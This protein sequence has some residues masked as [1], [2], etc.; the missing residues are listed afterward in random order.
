MWNYELDT[1][2][3]KGK[4]KMHGNHGKIVYA[5]F[6]GVWMWI[7]PNYQI[8]FQ[9]NCSKIKFFPEVRINKYKG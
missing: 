6:G 9:Y 3:L 5:I 8:K 4:M 7:E 1:I 2:E